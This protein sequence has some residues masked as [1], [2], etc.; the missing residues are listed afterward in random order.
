MRQSR[1]HSPEAL[2][3][4]A[5]LLMLV[6][7]ILIALTA[8]KSDA[9][10]VKFSAPWP[11]HPTWSN[12]AELL[13]NSEEAPIGRWL[14][15][16]IFV[17]SASTALVLLVD[18]LAAFGFSRLKP[19]FGR[20]VFALVIATLM[21]PGQVL[22]VPMYLLLNR[23]GWIDTYWALI[24]PAGAGA[25]GVFLLYQFF[26]AIPRELE[27]AARLDGCSSLRVYWHVMLPG[28]RPA[29]ATLA[30][31]TFIGV[32]N[33]FLNPLVFLDSI[34]KFTLPVGIAL[35]QSSYVTEYGKT[36]AAS[37]VCTLPVLVLFLLFNG[38][39]VRGVAAGALKE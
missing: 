36:L 3:L 6:P 24:V 23:L 15:N 34:N 11:L 1:F 35:F 27:D 22:L 14:F 18:S 31:L 21:V 9:E 7:I 16:S 29:L 28:A 13:R 12:F 32:W 4:P 39:I 17:S 38:L 19:P 33:D 8:F 2:L 37:V 5:C 25:F 20:S 30:I 26:N 10:V